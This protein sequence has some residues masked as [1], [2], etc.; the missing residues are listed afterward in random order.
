M[1][2]ANAIEILS[3]STHQDPADVMVLFGEDSSLKRRVREHLLRDP[4][5]PGASLDSVELDVET[6]QWNDLRD[7]L[8]TGSLFS[9]G[10]QRTILLRSADG[11][12]SKYRK[13][14][15][16]YVA[17]PSTVGRLLLEVK[18]FAS[19]TLLYKAINKTGLLIQCAI[20]SAGGRS[21]KPDMTKLRSFL[22]DIIAPEHQ[23]KLNKGAA[24][25]LI[26]M[27][28][29][30]V[31]MLETDIAKL[32]V[33]TDPGGTINDQMVQD[34]VGGWRS[35]TTWEVID[36]AAAGNSAEALLQLDRLLASGEKALGLL[37]Q[38]A[39]SLRRL[40]LA[41][42]SID[43]AERSGQSVSMGT[44]LQHAGFRPFDIKKG[45]AQLRKMGRQRAQRML[46]WL[47]EAD[48]K[49]KGSHSTDERARWVLEE[50][51]LHM[52]G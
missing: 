22:C 47:L 16:S 23:C 8:Q 30:D 1:P 31:G 7:E 34:F 51:F 25:T 28:G 6:A 35:K 2:P 48:L 26:D 13:E 11:F 43:H 36:A 21:T 4:E 33:Y 32:A 20:P 38:I 19:N 14:L 3:A 45:E 49:L 9:L 5:D 24:D 52:A 27:V 12:V 10:Q 29:T 44:A 17:A 41:A 37:P 50:L 46:G 18:S 40:G 42:A 15:E 39:W